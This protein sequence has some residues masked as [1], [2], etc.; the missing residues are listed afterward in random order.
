MARIIKGILGEVSGLVG[1][2]VGAVVRG[3]ATIRSRPRKSTKAPQQSQINQRSKFSLVTE[4]M[5]SIR[6][7]LNI[8]FQSY[9]KKMSPV[10]AAV[11][12]ALSNSVIG[13]APNFS[14]D[15]PSIVLS[16]GSLPDS[17]SMSVGEVGAGHKL[18]FTWDLA[19]EFNPAEAVLY[20]SDRATFLMYNVTKNKFLRYI[21][22][23]DRSAGNISLTV[24][25][26]F[27][28][29]TLHVYYFF[30]SAD[31]KSVSNSGYL[32]TAKTSA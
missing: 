19:Q 32:G 30:S 29:D 26:L 27:A 11:Q 9:N 6:D 3:V 17:P 24:P 4:F 7:L 18:V 1:T 13:L 15:L 2:V 25:F 21:S 23:V 10:N 12:Y 31:G 8:G 16:K 5:F 22:Y 20:G 28:G 14:L